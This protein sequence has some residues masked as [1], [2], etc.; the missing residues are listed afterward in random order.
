VPLCLL[1]RGLQNRDSSTCGFCFQP[2]K[3]M[4]ALLF[5][6]AQWQSVCSTSQ[7][8]QQKS[9]W[10]QLP[11]S[12]DSVAK[13]SGP[14]SS[15]CRF[16]NYNKDVRPRPTV[17]ASKKH[18]LSSSNSPAH[19]AQTFP[20]DRFCLICD[21]HCSTSCVSC[22]QDFC[23]THLYACPECDNQFCSRCLDDHRADGHWS[24]SDTAAELSRGWRN[25]SASDGS[26]IR[27]LR[28]RTR[29]TAPAVTKPYVSLRPA[30]SQ[31]ISNTHQFETSQPHT[32]RFKSSQPHA[33]RSVN[34]HACQTSPRV[35]LRAV[36]SL[37]GFL[38]QAIRQSLSSAA[39]CTTVNLLAQSEILLEVSR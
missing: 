33:Y 15:H 31:G 26:A 5:D 9:L 21:A 27:S 1:S 32:R 18:C 28:P 24:D 13:C 29:R 17:E 6:S 12:P 2:S 8:K 4:I 36:I 23:S 16:N 11:P 34:S 39:D 37:F 10:R 14:Q 22:D 30:A 38:L 7:P 19:S 35:P 20:R 25:M 3:T